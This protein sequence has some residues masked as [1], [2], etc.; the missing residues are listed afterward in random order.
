MKTEIVISKE[1]EQQIPPLTSEEFET[2]EQNILA[3]GRVINPLNL[4][5][6]T[7]VDGHNRYRILQKHP[8]IPYTVFEKEFADKYEVIAWICKNQLGRRNL[9]TEQRK[10]LLRKKF[11]A[12]KL[13]HGGQEGNQNRAIRS[14]Q[15][16]NFE[17]LEKTC[18]R[19]AK[20]VGVGRTTVICAEKNAASV[21]AVEEVLPGIR[22]DILS[23]MIKHVERE[24]AAIATA[25][26]EERLELSEQ[27]RRPKS[28]QRQKIQI[29]KRNQNP[30]SI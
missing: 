12:E 16:G 27:L 1:F 10:Y 8:E 6:G 15:N 26:L 2:L 23:G 21:D 13:T 24:V 19:I 5:K 14:Y 11:E 4:W 22:Q 9:T 25:P 20:E 17:N 18:E 7:L 30:I 3:D 29:S 28:K